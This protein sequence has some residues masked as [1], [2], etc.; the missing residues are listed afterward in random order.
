[1]DYKEEGKNWMKKP[2]KDENRTWAPLCSAQPM[3]TWNV[4]CGTWNV[5]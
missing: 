4:E 1:M 2:K 3:T 5:G